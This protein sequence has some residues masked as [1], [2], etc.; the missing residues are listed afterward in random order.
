MSSGGGSSK[1]EQFIAGRGLSRRGLLQG[2]AVAGGTVAASQALEFSFPRPAR[3]DRAICGIRAGS[4]DFPSSAVVVSNASG[5][6]Q[7]ALVGT[8]KGVWERYLSRDVASV[9]ARLVPDVIRQSN[10]GIMG[11]IQQDSAAVV[12]DLA[13]EWAAFERIDGVIAEQW[14]IRN[15]EVWVDASGGFATVLCWA[16]VEGGSRWCYTDLGLM[17]YGLTKVDG[18]WKICHWIESFGIDVDP[19]TG[20]PGPEAFSFDFSYPVTELARAQDFYDQLLGP[21][22]SSTPTQATYL[23]DRA[24]FRLEKDGMNSLATVTDKLANGWATFY[25]P[26]VHA[27]RTQLL[28]AGAKF[29]LGSDTVLLN[30]GPDQYAIAVDKPN[31]TSNPFIIKQRNYSTD[32]PPPATPVGLDGSDPAVVAAQRITSAWVKMQSSVIGEAYGSSGRW[33]DDT[34]TKTR[35]LELGSGLV[36]VLSTVYWPRYDRSSAGLSVDIAARSVRVRSLGARTIVSYMI[37]MKGTGVHPFHETAFVTHVLDADFKPLISM[38]VAANPPTG[39]NLGLDY[40]GYPSTK[41]ATAGA[42]FYTN[43]MELGAP[44]VDSGYRGWWSASG[45]VFGLYKSGRRR[46]GAPRRNKP[47]GYMSFWVPSAQDAYDWLQS[48]RSAFPL[49]KAINS[50]IGVD[51]QPG[52][53]QVLATDSEGNLLLCSEYTG[54]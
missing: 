26:D 24:R 19:Q 38:T 6:D 44:Y 18:D 15:A 40:T 25:V 42:K 28:A 35:G 9:Q 36:N 48:Q 10:R 12:A 2:I 16:D 49:I 54:R 34:R 4:A 30:D 53:T 47:S 52:Y 14:T 11:R 8:I 45:L 13:G 5:V 3:A 21:A 29:L 41:P 7:A 17:L 50:K 20:V 46:H 43:V 51:R 39:M 1:R 22:E 27:K 32:G 37:D 23:I 31:L 33:F